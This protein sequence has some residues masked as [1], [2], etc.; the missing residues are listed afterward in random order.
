MGI[1]LDA[2]DDALVKAQEKE[3][4]YHMGAS[5][6]GDKCGRKIW[7]DF[8]WVTQTLHC[9]QLLRLFNRGH[10]EE[11][12]FVGW[13]R[14]AG[15]T[16]WQHDP[17]TGKQYQFFGYK[18]HFGGEADG[19]AE[20][21]IPG[22]PYLLE[23]KTHNDDSFKSLV[24]NGVEIDKEMHYIQM[25]I[26]MGAFGLDRALYLAINKNNDAIHDEVVK[27]NR[28]VYDKYTN[29]AQLL[30][31]APEPPPRISRDPSWWE[32]KFC[33]HHSVCHTSAAPLVNCRTCAHSTPV[34]NG[35]WVCENTLALNM[36]EIPAQ[37]VLTGCTRYVRHPMD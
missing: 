21:I 9:G 30:I 2:I 29:R 24:R 12:R 27:F 11:D 3:P 31:D 32:C 16:V 28:Q 14:A 18:G 25:Q 37:T 33:N 35:K 7:Y 17:A 10:L 8:R 4:R 34:H 36:G 23:F 22:G 13:L 6:I 5:S 20:G 1:V 19:V 26:Y 15:A